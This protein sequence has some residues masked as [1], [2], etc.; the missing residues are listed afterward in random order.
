MAVNHNQQN[1]NLLTQFLAKKVYT[2]YPRK[3]LDEFDYVLAAQTLFC[4][5]LIDITGFDQHIWSRCTQLQESNIP[6]IIISPKQSV[7]IHQAGLGHGAKNVLIKPLV[8]KELLAIIH[9]LLGG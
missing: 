1:L 6:F 3:S 7:V 2:T 9:G 4:M 5:A 8:V